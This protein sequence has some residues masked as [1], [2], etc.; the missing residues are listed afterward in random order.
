MSFYQLCWA[1]TVIRSE[2]DPLHLVHEWSSKRDALCHQL[3]DL[4]QL[5]SAS[6]V[7]RTEGFWLSEWSKKQNPL[8]MLRLFKKIGRLLRAG[9]L[10]TEI[11]AKFPIDE[12]ATAARAAAEPGKPGKTLLLLH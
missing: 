12:A 10:T 8:T 7:A 6:A 4:P 2:F 3:L 11:G 5:A 1:A 9:V